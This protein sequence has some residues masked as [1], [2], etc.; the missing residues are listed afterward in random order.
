MINGYLFSIRGAHSIQRNIISRCTGLYECSDKRYLIY[1][2]LLK[3]GE[4]CLDAYY[5]HP[6]TPL[7]LNLNLNGARQDLHQ[8]ALHGGAAHFYTFAQGFSMRS[9]LVMRDALIFSAT[10]IYA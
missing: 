5:S 2:G 8:I 6:H 10:E 9:W 3:N 4:R 1:I 7:N